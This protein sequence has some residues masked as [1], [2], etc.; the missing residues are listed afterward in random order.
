MQKGLYIL[1]NPHLLRNNVLKIGMSLRLEERVYDYDAVFSD[2]Y[3]E[4]CYVTTNLTKEQILYIEK[5]IL[6]VTKDKR[7]LELSSEYRYMTDIFTLLK[8]HNIVLDFFDKYNI[9]YELLEK[10]KFKKP[11][12]TIKEDLNMEQQLNENIINP[13]KNSK[14]EEIQKKYLNEI[15][16]E[17]KQNNGRVLCV[18]PTGFGKTM[19]LYNLINVIEY[20]KIIVFTPR[21][22]LNKQTASNK[23]TNILSD[24]YTKIIFDNMNKDC[25]NNITE[26]INKDKKIIIFLCYQSSLQL[27]NIIQNNTIDLVVFDEAHFIQSWEN[28]EDEHIKYYMNSDNV[29]NRLFLTATPT[30]NMLDNTLLFGKSINKVKIYELITYGILC[31]IETIIKKMENRKNEYHNLYSMICNCM[32]KYN[33]KKGIIYTNTQENAKS[34]YKLFCASDIDIKAYIFISEKVEELCEEGD[35]NLENFENNENQCIIITCKKIDYG[36]DNIWIDFIC[37]ADEKHGLIEIRQIMGRGLRNNEEIYPNKKLH[38][39]LPIYYDEIGRENS[40][41]NVI[42]YLRY[43]IEEAGQDIITV[44]D[45]ENTGRNNDKHIL[46]TKNYDGEDIPSEICNMLS[47]TS[48]YKYDNFKRFLRE[49]NVY[50]EQT[51]NQLQSKHDEWLIVFCKVRERYKK[52]CF[53]DIHPYNRS[54][55]WDKD[56]C[57][58]NIKKAERELKNKISSDRFRRMTMQ[59]KLDELNIIDNKIPNIDL[60]W[61]YNI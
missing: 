33:K 54:Y 39:L 14:R 9:D 25:K 6:D 1:S 20:N 17:F 61:Y 53:R 49:N 12:S 42:A 22:I 16:C 8:Y 59:K 18:A 29:K 15:I 28:K 10:P 57:I 51:Y 23:Y 52:F 24:E 4:Y 5:Q 30:E 38:V 50:N 11:I 34:L 47:T 45:F 7:N 3:Y 26:F 13:F 19:I 32:K 35:D 27:Y 44:N 56:D 2:N 21:R 46:N 60:E 48:Y 40:Y 55:Y 31:N 41:K 43:I 36:Y 58:E 37:F